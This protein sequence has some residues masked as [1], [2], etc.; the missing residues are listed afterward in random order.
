MR[1]EGQSVVVTGAAS[2]LGRAVSQRLSSEGARVFGVDLNEAG[3][4]ET[5]EIVTAAGGTMSFGTADISD[6]MSAHGV[7]ANAID[8]K[9]VV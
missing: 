9:S 1:F 7:V 4:A 3:L 2:G 6:R 8:R 5:K